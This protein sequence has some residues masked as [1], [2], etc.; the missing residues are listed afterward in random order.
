MKRSIYAAK[1]AA[2]LVVLAL[3]TVPAW[4]A[5]S[6]TNFGLLHTPLGQAVLSQDG[7]TYVQVTTNRGDG[8]S[9]FVGESDS[10]IFITP[11]VSWLEPRDFVHG[12][13]YG[14]LNGMTNQ[15]L[16]S[17]R[18]L[19]RSWNDD[20]DDEDEYEQE[21]WV[22]QSVGGQYVA[23]VDL[24]P[25]GGS[26][27]TAIAFVGEQVVGVVSNVSGTFGV[28]NADW[29]WANPL[30]RAAPFWRMPDGSVGALFDFWWP[31]SFGPFG[32]VG[33]RY[34][35]RCENPTN[36]AGTVS[37]LDVLSRDLPAPYDAEP[38][39]FGTG[40]ISFQLGDVRLGMFHRPHRAFNQALLQATN[41]RLSVI[42]QTND[43]PQPDLLAS[44]AV[45]LNQA[46]AFRAEFLPIDVAAEDAALIVSGIGDVSGVVD[47]ELGTMRIANTNGGCLIS[48]QFGVDP[49]FA[50]IVVLAGGVPVGTNGVPRDMVWLTTSQSRRIVGAGLLARSL[51]SLSGFIVR[52]EG[53]TTFTTSTGQ[54]FEGDEVRLL[55]SDPVNFVNLDTCTLSACGLSSF[56]LT[57]E[58]SEPF[59]LPMLGITRSGTN[60]LLSWPDPNEVFELECA[61]LID[62][63]DREIVAL[64]FQTQTNGVTFLNG[65]RSQQLPIETFEQHI[66]R[67]RHGPPR[68]PRPVD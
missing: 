64:F 22:W 41:G 18:G 33:T 32:P 53:A 38:T 23:G 2:S 12:D 4:A 16:A 31:T 52:L 25:L 58:S 37:R 10:G 49:R 8:V 54:Q 68:P 36:L 7:N 43:P 55:A 39:N 15:R 40:L 44:V 17:A 51:N 21:G 14:Q 27:L 48:V 67:L 6:I 63:P 59:V 34:F 42:L 65:F 3:L 24:S 20:D 19:Y 45:D 57:G 13:V 61:S 29:I 66:F 47:T 5:D 1:G 11:G 35:V 60:V 28:A 26:S 62:D 50:Q 56:T 46:T 9:I 30:R